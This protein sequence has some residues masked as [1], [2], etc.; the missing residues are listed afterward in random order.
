MVNVAGKATTTMNPT[1][2]SEKGEGRRGGSSGAGPA[3]GL[4]RGR[5]VNAVDER[6]LKSWPY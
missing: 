2:V 6:S 4:I 1:K 5:G 3:L